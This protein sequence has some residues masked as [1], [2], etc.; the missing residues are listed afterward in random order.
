MRVWFRRETGLG[1][2]LEQWLEE[3]GQ[4]SGGPQRGNPLPRQPIALRD[5]QANVPPPPLHDLTPLDPL[6]FNTDL[7]VTV[8]S[9]T[10]S[11]S[12]SLGIIR[13]PDP[14]TILMEY[15]QGALTLFNF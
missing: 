15:V 13:S 2:Q 4:R 11:D 9:D 8:A 6:T 3:L 5:D 12:E 7:L 1:R 14:E 10:D